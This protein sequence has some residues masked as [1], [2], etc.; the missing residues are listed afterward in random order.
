MMMSLSPTAFAAEV[1]SRAP[2]ASPA[3]RNV[4]PASSG[5]RM[6]QAATLATP[7]SRKAGGDRLAGFAEADEREARGVAKTHVVPIGG[8]SGEGAASATVFGN[9]SKVGRPS[10]IW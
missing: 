2:I 5:N 10:G 3:A 4:A 6:S 8:L 7:A 1:A 9:R